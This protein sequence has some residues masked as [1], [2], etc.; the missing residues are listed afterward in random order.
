MKRALTAAALVLLP[1]AASA[2]PTPPPPMTQGPM[3]VERISSGPLVAIPDV[4]ITDVDSHTYALIG[5]YAGWLTDDKF[6][7][8]GAGYWLASYDYDHAMAYGGLSV[9]WL[10]HV[11]DPVG[12]T[13]KGLVGGGS[14]TLTGVGT[15][16]YPPYG[17]GGP[18]VTPQYGPNYA[19]TYRYSEGFFIAEPEVGVLLNFSRHMRLTGGASY[20]FIQGAGSDNH[21]LSGATG[22][23]GLQIGGGS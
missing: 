14:A 15:A 9:Q 16:Y 13:L 8:G 12:F 23:I 20:R 21:R 1:I 2:Q 17:P 5:T 3:T 18:V 22:S 11:K 4:K 7:I 10:E 6:F 19:V